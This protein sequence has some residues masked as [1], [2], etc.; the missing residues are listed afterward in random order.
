TT[1]AAAQAVLRRPSQT[2]T[3]TLALARPPKT[4]GGS[5]SPKG[6]AR[7]KAPPSASVAKR[8]AGTLLTRVRVIP[9]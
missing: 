5:A 7:R 6:E 3:L 2:L 8:A 4:A 1:P 9:G